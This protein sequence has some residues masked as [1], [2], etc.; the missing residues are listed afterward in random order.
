MGRGP[1]ASA[2]STNIARNH[3]GTMNRAAQMPER[4]AARLDVVNPRPRHTG[5][6]ASQG[7]L[8]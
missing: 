5:K 4:M 6:R 2:D 1:F 3:A 7:V 8:L